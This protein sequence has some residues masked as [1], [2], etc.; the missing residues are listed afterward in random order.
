MSQGLCEMEIIVP[1][2]W[3]LHGSDAL[4]HSAW[5]LPQ[6]GSE[7]G[8]R[9][10][11]C[12]A[13][14][15]PSARNQGSE[16]GAPSPHTSAQPPLAETY[17]AACAGSAKPRRWSG[18]RWRLLLA[19][20]RAS[21]GGGLA[22]A[23]HP[24][25]PGTNMSPMRRVLCDARLTSERSEA[26]ASRQELSAESSG[27]QATRAENIQGR[28][29]GGWTPGRPHSQVRPPHPGQELDPR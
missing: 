29:C 2:F 14:R 6:A 9:S 17:S 24:A 18:Q 16:E 20:L 13:T 19:S 10:P 11:T 3:L 1:S 26:R 15:D 23:R 25:K 28:G 7:D 5:T 21:G 12:Y 8:Q 22:R 27:A 4:K